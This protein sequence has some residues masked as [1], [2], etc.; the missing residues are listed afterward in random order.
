MHNLRGQPRVQGVSRRE[1]SLINRGDAAHE[2]P[3][4]RRHLDVL[5]VEGGVVGGG[6][7]VWS[8]A[9]LRIAT[10][11]LGKRAVVTK[12]PLLVRRIAEVA[13]VDGSLVQLL[14]LVSAV[15][16]GVAGGVGQR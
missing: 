9:L 2:Y 7:N 3:V 12:L 1:H 16:E 4:A 6:R 13:M 14:R 15:G 8:S 11:E 10:A 5:D